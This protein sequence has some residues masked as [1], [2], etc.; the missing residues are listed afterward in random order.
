MGG[1][2]ALYRI[3]YGLDL[4]VLVEL[5]FVWLRLVAMCCEHGDPPFGSIQG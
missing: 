1:R 4:N 2:I 5:K 3:L